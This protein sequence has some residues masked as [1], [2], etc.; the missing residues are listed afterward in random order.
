MANGPPDLNNLSWRTGKL[1]ETVAE[2]H[3]EQIREL[4][5]HRMLVDELIGQIRDTLK[6]EYLTSEQ[7]ANRYLMRTDLREQG[8]VRRE[9]LMF[10]VGLLS[11]ASVILQVL[12][13]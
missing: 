2:H 11:A 1:E 3:R 7:T 9:W 6:D 13:V 12:H 10:L 5:Q 8:A 4:S